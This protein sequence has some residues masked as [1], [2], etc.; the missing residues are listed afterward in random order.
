VHQLD[1]AARHFTARLLDGELHALKLAAAEHR[2]DARRF[3]QNADL[4]RIGRHCRRRRWG[5]EGSGEHAGG[6]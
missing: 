1:L 3:H 4:Q 2:K 6:C 5:Q